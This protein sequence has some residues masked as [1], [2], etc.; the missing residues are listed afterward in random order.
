MNSNNENIIIVVIINVIVKLNYIFSIIKKTLIKE[1][2]QYNL[3]K[4]VKSFF[5]NYTQ[6]NYF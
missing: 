4:I 3:Q 6:N 5:G 1:N 2:W